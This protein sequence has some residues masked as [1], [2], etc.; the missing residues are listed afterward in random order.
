[1]SKR[2][3]RACNG[4]MRL[5]DEPD[6]PCRYCRGEG[7]VVDETADGTAEDETPAQEARR[8]LRAAMEAM[9]KCES[10]QARDAAEH[11][12]RMS[13]LNIERLIPR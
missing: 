12:A 13:Q 11:H 2:E 4:Y 9:R 5:S 1:M 7:E 10:G 3:C 6:R 8:H